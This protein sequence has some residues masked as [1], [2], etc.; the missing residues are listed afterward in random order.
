[1]MLGSYI[2]PGPHIPVKERNQ[3]DHVNLVNPLHQL[4]GMVH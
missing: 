3:I 1:M 2:P 4:L